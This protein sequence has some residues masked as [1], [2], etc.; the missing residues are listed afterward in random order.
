MLIHLLKEYLE[1]MAG[2]SLTIK[3]M[4]R[5]IKLIEKDKFT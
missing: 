3:R 5:K 4:A 1:F 2:M